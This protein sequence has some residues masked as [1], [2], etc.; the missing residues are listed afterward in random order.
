MGIIVKLDEKTAEKLKK[1][2][3]KRG[4]LS[5]AETIRFLVNM[6]FER[7]IESH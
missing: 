4:H 5:Y 7:E 3:E 1:I 2:K 6:Y